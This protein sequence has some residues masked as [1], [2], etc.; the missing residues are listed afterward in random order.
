MVVRE[1]IRYEYHSGF[2]IFIVVYITIIIALFE[3]STRHHTIEMLAGL[4]YPDVY[5][6][7]DYETF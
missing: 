5:I 3:W 2:H 4:D 6:L 1:E 7:T